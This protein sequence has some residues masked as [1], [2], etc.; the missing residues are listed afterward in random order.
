MTLHDARTFNVPRT[1]GTWPA[2]RLVEARAVSPPAWF[3]PGPIR[4][5]GGAARHFASGSGFCGGIHLKSTLGNPAIK[6]NI[7]QWFAKLPFSHAGFFAKSPNPVCRIH[8]VK[9][10]SPNPGQR[11]G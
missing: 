11:K 9:S 5:R 7:Y 1:A 8:C 4:I 3:L 2:Q 6:T 10:N